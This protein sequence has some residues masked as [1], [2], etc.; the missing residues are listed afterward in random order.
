MTEHE[1]DG[2]EHTAEESEL[3]AAEV[4]NAVEEFNLIVDYDLALTQNENYTEDVV[5][6]TYSAT[7]DIYEA[8]LENVSEE[9]FAELAD[10][11]SADTSSTAA[12]ED[13]NTGG[14]YEDVAKGSMVAN[15]DN[16]IY[17]ESR[18]AGDVGIVQTEYGFHIIY[19]IAQNERADWQD[20][21]VSALTSETSE[22]FNTMLEEIAADDSNVKASSFKNYAYKKSIEL[23]ENIYGGNYFE[24][25]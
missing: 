20:A 14:L 16:W 5:N 2:S 15:F 22:T 4:A 17:D 12:T 18:K 7:Y 21:V 9:N 24:V 6:A 11:Y 3:F 10:N 8:Y 25:E 19:F 13:G 23:I 1:E